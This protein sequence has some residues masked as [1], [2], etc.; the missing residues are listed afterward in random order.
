MGEV[1]HRAESLSV[2]SFYNDNP[3]SPVE[4]EIQFSDAD[5]MTEIRFEHEPGSTFSVPIETLLPLRYVYLDTA[6]SEVRLINI[7]H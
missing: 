5:E 3:N 6:S 7:V 2:L 4:R 1:C